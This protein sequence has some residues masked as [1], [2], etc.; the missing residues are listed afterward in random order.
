VVTNSFTSSSAPDVLPR[1][2]ADG[3]LE[4]RQANG[5]IGHRVFW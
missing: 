1:A 2:G 4:T 3:F 5:R